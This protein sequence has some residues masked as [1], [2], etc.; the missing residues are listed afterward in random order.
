MGL[1]DLLDVYIGSEL[2]R[3]RPIKWSSAIGEKPEEEIIATTFE[4]VCPSC[5]QLMTF[6]LSEVVKDGDLN[7][8]SCKNCGAG[9]ADGKISIRRSQGLRPA[10]DS[11]VIVDDDACPFQDPVEAGELKV[12]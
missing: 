10:N 7:R 9:S 2:M 5:S 6:E 3:S 1:Y 4:T 11:I 12:S 8:V